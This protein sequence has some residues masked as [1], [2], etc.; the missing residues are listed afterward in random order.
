V[1]TPDI[2]PSAVVDP[3][4]RIGDGVHIGPFCVVGPNVRIG[5]GSELLSHVVV[6]GYTTIGSGNRVFPFASIGHQPQDLKYHGEASEVIIGDG[7]TIREGVTINPGTE[8]GGM[9]TKIGSHNLLMAYSHVAHDCLLGDQ[10]VLANGATLAGHVEIEDGVI[11]GGHTAVLQ[12]VRIGRYAMVG[13]TAG[14]TKDV[15][16]FCL[17]SGGYRPG[18]AGLNLI[19]LRR[20]QFSNEQIQC[21][22]SMYRILFQ[23]AGP[24]EDRLREAGGVAGEDVQAM[25]L[26]QFVQA[27][28]RGLLLHRRDS[29]ES[30]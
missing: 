2:H 25:H 27:A 10:V 18:L 29:R 24:M 22:K 5:E 30:P 19:G 4:A 15:P 9:L 1:S 6:E 7:N 16:P 21:L 13:G 3:A 8:G 28:K 26:L 20:R 12:F 14:I 11:L 23:S 17:T